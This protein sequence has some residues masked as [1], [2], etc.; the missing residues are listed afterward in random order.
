[1]IRF[2]TPDNVGQAIASAR[3]AAGLTQ[4]D[5]CQKID[6][7]Y[8]T[9]TKI[10]RGAIKAPNAYTLAKIAAITQTTV[11]SL[12]AANQSQ[13]NNKVITF[14]STATSKH[15]VRVVFVNFNCLL[16]NNFQSILNQI[17]IDFSLNQKPVDD[18]FYKNYQKLIVGGQSL[19]E[20]NQSV[21]DQFNLKKFDLIDY[22]QRLITIN[23]AWLPLLRWIYNH[24]LVGL[25]VNGPE[26][27]IGC[28]QENC[29]F[30]N[31]DFPIIIKSVKQRTTWPNANFL[32]SALK[33]AEP[34]EPNQILL[35]DDQLLAINQAA[36]FGWQCLLV[37]QINI[38]QTIRKI[39]QQ[40]DFINSEN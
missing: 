26:E 27:L 10:E 30:L 35:I 13:V 4:Q 38:E 5:L 6:I 15:N 7:S 21:I 2:K 36:P 33:S 12:L 14:E 31:F 25:I 20:F 29:Q 37:D 9:L 11:E 1:M 16:S 24:Y 22:F 23:Q 28:L 18:F 3:R 19:D 34:A 40:L 17:A 39:R 32:D 8:S